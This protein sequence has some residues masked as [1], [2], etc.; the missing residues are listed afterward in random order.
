MSGGFEA[1]VHIARAPEEVWAH[2]TDWARA[3]EWMN[4][5]EEVRPAGDGPPGEGTRILFRSRGSER[6][7]TIVGWSPPELLALRSRQGGM[8]ATYEYSCAPEADGTRLSLHAR[9]EAS[10]LGWRLAGPLIQLLM[11]R[12]DSGQVAALKRVLEER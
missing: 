2:L 10:G 6:E 9:C 1:T 7:S 11:K 12:A 3:S 4:G 8:T 5:V